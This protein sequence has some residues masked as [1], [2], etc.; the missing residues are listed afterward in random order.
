MAAVLN[1]QTLEY[2][3][4]VNTPDYHPADWIINPDLSA[5]TKT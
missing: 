3:E 5:L 1:K 2:L 4:S